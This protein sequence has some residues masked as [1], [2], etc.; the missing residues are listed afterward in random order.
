MSVGATGFEPVSNS[1]GSEVE[2]CTCDFCQ[3]FRAASALHLTCGNCRKLTA[4][5]ADLRKLLDGWE[6]LPV[7]SRKAILTL[8]AASASSRSLPP[9]GGAKMKTTRAPEAL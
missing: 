3:G 1:D 2:Q 6:R 5:D 4:S 8:A 7:T 9:G